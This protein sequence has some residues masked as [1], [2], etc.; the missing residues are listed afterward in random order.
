MQTCYMA[1]RL[2]HQLNIS[3]D[4]QGA[5]CKLS[6]IPTLFET[7]LS[8]ATPLESLATMSQESVKHKFTVD[9][10]DTRGPTRDNG[11]QPEALPEVKKTEVHPN[12][13]NN[14]E[15]VRIQAHKLARHLLMV[16]LCQRRVSTL[17]ARR[18]PYWSGKAFAS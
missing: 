12:G 10:L 8:V 18:P 4:L 14:D 6:P 2:N 1:C 13:S 11:P 7:F 17:S 9:A 16:R 3:R 5:V 15:N